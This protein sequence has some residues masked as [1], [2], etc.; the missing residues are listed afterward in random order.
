MSDPTPQTTA[1]KLLAENFTRSSP[2]AQAL[3]DPL[4]DTPIVVT[5]NELRSYEL[6]PRIMRNP[7]YDDIKASIKERGLDAPPPITRRPGA[8]HYIIRN[9][10]NT[11]LSILCELWSETKDERFFRISCQFRPWPERGEI[12]ALTGHLAENELHGGL[13]FIERAGRREGVGTL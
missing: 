8:D 6:N 5:L 4:C 7:L 12:V 1:E 11:R 10:G 2:I 13:S 9:G 3:S